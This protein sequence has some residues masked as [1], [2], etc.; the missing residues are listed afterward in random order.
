VGDVRGFRVDFRDAFFGIK[1]VKHSSR[2]KA[3]ER[4]SEVCGRVE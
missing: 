3:L 4:E 1:Y 2:K